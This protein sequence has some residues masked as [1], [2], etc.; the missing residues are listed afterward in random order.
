MSRIIPEPRLAHT[1][2]NGVPYPGA[3]CNTYLSGTSTPVATYQDAAL[4]IPHANPVVALNDGRFPVI[5]GNAGIEY[6]FILTDA[7]GGN[8]RTID[9]ASPFVL[10]QA[11]IG[12]SL[13]P[14]TEAEDLEGVT[15]VNYAYAPGDA[16]RYGVSAGASAAANTTALHNA[17]AATPNF[18][19]LVLPEGT[20]EIN[21]IAIVDHPIKL[22]GHGLGKHSG[23]SAAGKTIIQC[24]D[25]NE[26]AITMKMTTGYAPY[27]VEGINFAGNQ[28]GYG[29]LHFGSDVAAGG[30]YGNVTGTVIDCAFDEFTT[31]GL[32]LRRVF[33]V[34]IERVDANGVRDAAT[35]SATVG[36]G[37]ALLANNPGS[38]SNTLD[39]TV[40]TIRDCGSSN[41]HKGIYVEECEVLRIINHQASGNN[42]NG[43]HCYA[44]EY[45]NNV[46]IDGGYFEVN[47]ATRVDTGWGA[48][49]TQNYFDIDFERDTS[50]TKPSN[51]ITGIIVNNPHFG[52]LTAG[53]GKIHFQHCFQGW[54]RARTSSLDS[55]LI[56]V[57]NDAAGLVFELTNDLQPQLESGGSFPTPFT[58][59]SNL[60]TGVITRNLD[61][62]PITGS[63]TGTLTGMTGSTT[64]T[65]SWCRYGNR[66]Q[67]YF[68]STIQGTSNSTSMTMTGL[69]AA[70]QPAHS[71]VSQVVSEIEDNGVASHGVA[72]FTAASGT[73]TFQLSQVSGSKIIT[74][75][76]AFTNSGAKG[77]LSGCRL[78]YYL[79]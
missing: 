79:D 75:S 62:R 4:T 8:P 22:K 49:L 36:Y 14:Q 40:V 41:C 17:I 10:T 52:L 11:E 60:S 3:K 77:I 19:T 44:R 16:R 35:S 50:S 15:P 48:T 61:V 47:N 78:D 71:N 25:T 74:S 63:F 28:I 67:L 55:A 24:T 56:A 76:T 23:F 7:S 13:H 69:P 64:G 57:G 42:R 66:V 59:L 33:D 31:Y 51:N 58:V 32:V 26:F 70:L 72:V 12:A 6:K 21:P 34:V 20:I 2:A 27:H 18:G 9:P 46:L 39:M 30:T 1:D 37:I 29:G 73:V 53:S 54:M 45:I 65:V 43:I 38:S 5:Y 68:N